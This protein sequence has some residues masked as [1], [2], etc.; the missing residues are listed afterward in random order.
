M[1][2]LINSD[3]AAV[4]TGSTLYLYYQDGQSIRETSS[5]DGKSWTASSTTVSD[6]LSP[7]GSPFTAYHVKYDGS[8]DSKETIHVLYRD[9]RGSLRET[10]KV[11]SE[12]AEAQWT[13][14]DVPDDIQNAPIETST[15]ASD[16]SHDDTTYGSFQWVFFVEAPSSGPIRVAAII[17]NKDNGWVWEHAKDLLEDPAT[18]LPGTSLATT[19]T[20]STAH[21]F[22]QDHDEN[23]VQYNG[24]YGSWNNKETVVKGDGVLPNTPIAVATSNAAESPHVFYVT[25]P[26]D[27]QLSSIQDYQGGTTTQVTAGTYEPGSNI[28]AVTLG[29][30]TYLFLRGPASDPLSIVSLVLEGGSWE[31]NGTV[32]PSS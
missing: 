6:E 24:G 23:I 21:L 14:I 29:C 16:V 32:V 31:D 8:L 1:A 18:A 20:I 12:G 26:S 3:L 19:V 9:S 17:R 25:R 5:Q 28:G 10:A 22:F 15:L 27:S 30:E 4:S 11:L 13:E 2:P 7:D